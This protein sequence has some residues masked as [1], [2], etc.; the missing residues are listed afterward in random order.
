MPNSCLP[1][2]MQYLDVVVLDLLFTKAGITTYVVMKD[3]ISLLDKYHISLICKHYDVSP[4][5][6]LLQSFIKRERERERERESFI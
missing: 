2:N 4:K 3:S 5:T 1:H 6:N